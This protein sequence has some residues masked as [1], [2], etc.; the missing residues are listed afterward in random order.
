MLAPAVAR[1]VAIEVSV[2]AFEVEVTV[3][4]AE[5][6]AV[7]PTVPPF[8]PAS[9]MMVC[10]WVTSRPI[11][12]APPPILFSS[13][14]R[15]TMSPTT[16]SAASAIW[17][18]EMVSPAWRISTA[19]SREVASMVMP[20]ARPVASSRAEFTRRPEE[21]RSTAEARPREFLS[22]LRCAFSE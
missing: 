1:S 20:V 16:A 8:V 22:R 15:V 2:A 13:M 14:M 6:I 4:V 12:V 18:A 19:V 7:A 5:V 3:T 9:P 10:A 21:R 11:S 17:L